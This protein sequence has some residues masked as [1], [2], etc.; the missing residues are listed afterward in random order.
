M[1]NFKA[2]YVEVRKDGSRLN[3][4]EG[5]AVIITKNNSIC[6]LLSRDDL[7]GSVPTQQSGHQTGLFHHMR[8]LS[9]SRSFLWKSGPD[10]STVIS[11]RKTPAV[12][13][14]R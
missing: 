12:A 2:S 7:L 1:F 8:C 4:A 10:E 9:T 11:L 6:K 14:R 5:V 13:P 3:L